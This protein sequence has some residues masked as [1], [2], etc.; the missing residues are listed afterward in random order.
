MR[1]K[2]RQIVA[3]AAVKDLIA[4]SAFDCRLALSAAADCERGHYNDDRFEMDE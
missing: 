4:V 1:I 3:N 2:R